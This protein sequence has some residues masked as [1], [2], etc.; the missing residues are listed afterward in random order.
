MAPVLGNYCLSLPRL[1]FPCLGLGAGLTVSQHNRDAAE[2]LD[3]LQRHAAAKG[4]DA[5]PLD[6]R[7]PE[8]PAKRR[9]GRVVGDESGCILPLDHK[10]DHCPLALMNHVHQ[11]VQ[12]SPAAR[13][14]RPCR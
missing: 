9:V 5:D 6:R 10:D 8:G 4:D 7:P 2:K 13:R 1:G 12:V 14:G 11:F 3:C